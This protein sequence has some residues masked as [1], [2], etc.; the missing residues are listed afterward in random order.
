MELDTDLPVQTLAKQPVNG[1]FA[2]QDD[3]TKP[4]CKTGD[5]LRTEQ[6]V[7]IKRRGSV[8]EGN[9]LALRPLSKNRSTPQDNAELVEG[10]GREQG[11]LTVDEEP[12]VEYLDGGFGWAI[13]ASKPTSPDISST[14]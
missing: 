10:A 8:P 9:D 4:I 1:S 12:S 11:V 14:F 6:D 13:V 5:W 2:A 3:I 7:Q